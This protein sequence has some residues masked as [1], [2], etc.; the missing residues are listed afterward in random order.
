MSKLS[1]LMTEIQKT[2]DE[3]GDLEVFDSEC[4]SVEGITVIDNSEDTYDSSWNMPKEFAQID[5]FR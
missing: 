1:D 5:S 3:H 4:F 2:I